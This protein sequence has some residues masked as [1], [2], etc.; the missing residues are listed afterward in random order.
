VRGQRPIRDLDDVVLSRW[1]HWLKRDQG[2]PSRF[3]E[4]ARQLDRNVFGTPNQP[5]K[6]GWHWA[7]FALNLLIYSGYLVTVYVRHH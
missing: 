5:P 4:W 7:A 2:P 6:R 1:Q 3:S